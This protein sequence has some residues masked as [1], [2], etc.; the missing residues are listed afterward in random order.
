LPQIGGEGTVKEARLRKLAGE[1]GRLPERE[2]NRILQDLT[3]GMSSSHREAVENYFR[4]LTES[5]R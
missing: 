2:R 5:Q 3:R 1:W 4:R